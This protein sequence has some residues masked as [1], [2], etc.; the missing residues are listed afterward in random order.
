MVNTLKGIYMKSRWTDKP[1]VSRTVEDILYQ[2]ITMDS[3]SQW[4]IWI[5]PAQQADSGNACSLLWPTLPTAS[6]PVPAQ[7]N[8]R[9]ITL[10]DITIN[11][12]AQSP[13]VILST[14]PTRCEISSL[15]MW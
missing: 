10:R 14:A 6:C 8:W 12:P 1:D 15:T 13:G 7:F 3:P 5:G 4:A 2:N 9:N 11:N